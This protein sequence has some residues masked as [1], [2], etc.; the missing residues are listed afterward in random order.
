MDVAE[1]EALSINVL[2]PI[3][4]NQ[5][6][7]PANSENPA[8]IFVSCSSG[9]DFLAVSEAAE[10]LMSTAVPVEVD[11]EVAPAAA[12]WWCLV[13]VAAGSWWL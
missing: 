5:P 9:D 8:N 2:V 7:S 6:N 13:A 10:G 12:V 3:S 11:G 1:V 4:E